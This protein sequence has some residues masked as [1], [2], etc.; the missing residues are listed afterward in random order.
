MALIL[1]IDDCENGL[2]MRKRLLEKQGHKVLVALTA[3]QG[4]KKFQSDP[5]ELVIADDCLK[6]TIGAEVAVAMKSVKPDIP[7]IVLSG[8]MEPPDDLRD[9]DAF[10]TKSGQLEELL[11][12]IAELL[13]RKD[14]LRCSIGQCLRE[15][16]RVAAIGWGRRDN[17]PADTTRFEAEHDQALLDFVRHKHFCAVCLSS[18]LSDE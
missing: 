13:G 6:E 3:E 9:I 12:I 5:V 7:F 2:S 8:G 17:T 4:L 11:K 1:C 18:D 16:Y 10:V 14:L 15:R